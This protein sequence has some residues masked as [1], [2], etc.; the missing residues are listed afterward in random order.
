MNKVI[1]I[2][3]IGADPVVRATQDGREIAMISVATTDSWKDK[4]SGERKDKTEWHKVVIFSQG[5]VNVV[6]KYLHKGDKVC[7]E[8][9][10]TTRKWTD[11]KG[12]ERYTTEVVLKGFNASLIML[13]AKKSENNSE[14]RTVYTPDGEPDFVVSN[15]DHLNFDDEISF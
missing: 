2:G 15:D 7:V 12:V 1:L 9:A 4:T 11:D 8:G 3:N 14:T 10:L 13:S 6:K 5:L